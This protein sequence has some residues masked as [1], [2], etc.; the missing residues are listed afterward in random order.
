[1]KRL[2]AVLMIV[3]IG[4][5]ASH[6]S[7]PARNAVPPSGMFDRCADRLQEI[8]GVMLEYYVDHR[9]LPGTLEQLQAMAAQEKEPDNLFVCPVSKLRYVY[10]RQG[11]PLPGITP[12]ARVV[13][14]DAEAVHEGHRW[15]VA[16][17]EP[18]GG[19]PLICRVVMLPK[20]LVQAY[21]ASQPAAK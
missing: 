17:T 11:I 18:V 8:C 14:Y 6:S 21:S 5:A 2:N 20:G 7:M 13:L 10:D 4:C 16:I 3:A 1:M 12:P 9:E 15:G 19:H